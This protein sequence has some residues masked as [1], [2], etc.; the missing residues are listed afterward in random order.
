MILEYVRYQIP[1]QNEKKAMLIIRTIIFNS[2]K[3]K[4]KKRMFLIL[5]TSFSTQTN[6]TIID[7]SKFYKETC[8]LLLQ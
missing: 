2:K 7:F 3:K 8:V 1:L 4:K 5:K 6:A